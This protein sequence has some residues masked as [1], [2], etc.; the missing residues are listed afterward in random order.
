M[1]VQDFEAFKVSGLRMR[2]PGVVY[3]P[4]PIETISDLHGV[5]QRAPIPMLERVP[6]LINVWTVILVFG[7]A[8]AGS[9]RAGS[10]RLR[11]P[12]WVQPAPGCLRFSRG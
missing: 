11:A 2:D 5:K 10:R 9:M 1:L 4:D 8:G 3:S 12:P 6:A 7:L